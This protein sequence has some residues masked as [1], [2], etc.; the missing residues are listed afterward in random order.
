MD[1]SVSIKKICLALVY[2]R[3]QHVPEL[4]EENHESHL[5]HFNR[6]IIK[7]DS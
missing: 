2:G 1:D 7:A 5:Q 4:F 3:I 6:K